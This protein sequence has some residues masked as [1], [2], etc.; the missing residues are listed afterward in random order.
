VATQ[1]AE[2]AVLIATYV[3]LAAV[4]V[5]LAFIEAFLVPQRVFG[6]I[7][8]LSVV[9]AVVGNIAVGSLGGLGTR[10]MTGAVIPV[11]SW[12]A[13]IGVLTAYAPGGDVVLPGQLKADPGVVHVTT[14]FLVLGILSGAVALVVTSRY[15]RRVNEPTPQS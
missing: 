11:V 9:L 13:A 7:E 2:R 12:F 5:L 1:A 8:G 4:G 15:T 6:G 3:V 14:A 10:T